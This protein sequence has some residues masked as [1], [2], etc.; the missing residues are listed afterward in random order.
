MSA[1]RVRAHYDELNQIAQRFGQEAQATNALL[2]NLRREMQTLENGD[3]VGPGARAFYGEMNGAV[4]PAVQ[5]LAKAL[6]A[7]RDTTL[8]IRAVIQE[9]EAEAARVFRDTNGNTGGIDTPRASPGT[10]PGDEPD[11]LF[12]QIVDNLDDLIDYVASP[13]AVGMILTNMRLGGTYAGQV[14][15]PGSHLVKE[16][17]SVSRHLTHIKAGNLASHIG[18]SAVKVSG[19]DKVMAFAQGVAGIAD[20]WTKN[21]DEYQALDG[22]RAASA[23]AYDAGAALLP[24]AGEL[25]GTVGGR[26]VGA[27]SG[28]QLGFWIGAGVGSVIPVVGTAAGAAVGTTA[29]ALVGGLAGGLA[30]DWLGNKAGDWAKGQLAN[31]HVRQNSINWI[32]ANIAQP[33]VD[34]VRGSVD[35]LWNAANS[36]TESVRSLVNSPPG[37]LAPAPAF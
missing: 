18:R 30:G 33:V 22:S 28:A 27:A 21:W 7:A 12:K 23:M 15:F 37:N 1:P 32:D 8:Q 2:Q 24:A 19:I 10:T 9:A 14:V 20:T 5:R 36:L 11:I 4:L 16:L 26:A 25:A 35:R 31:P 34:T 29:G 6:D 13:I 17:A 3:W